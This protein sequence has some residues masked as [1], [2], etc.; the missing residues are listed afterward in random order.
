MS[1]P[2]KILHTRV[3]DLGTRRSL[4]RDLLES[5]S[6]DDVIA[7]RL[8]EHTGM[9]LAKNDVIHSTVVLVHATVQVLQQV[10]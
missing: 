4:R 7:I 10:L 5:G 1:Q 2:E 8:S 3:Y 9:T 6:E